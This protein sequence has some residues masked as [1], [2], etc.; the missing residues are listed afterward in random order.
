MKERQCGDCQ[1]CCELLAVKER[2]HLPSGKPYAFHKPALQRCGNQC[3]T[4]CAIY[5]E[6][7][8]PISC[9]AFECEWL[10]GKFRESDR[11]DRSGVVVTLKRDPGG[12]IRACIFGVRTKISG[13]TMALDLKNSGAHRTFAALRAMPGI[14]WIHFMHAQTEPGADLAFYR[15]GLGPTDW[16]AGRVRFP[17]DLEWIDGDEEREMVREL[18]GD[19]VTPPHRFREKLDNLTPEQQAQMRDRLEKR[20]M[21]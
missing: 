19:G 11:P 12:R 20:R 17:E 9:R 18:F 4:G 6:D 8:L 2:G 13:T 10:L 1:L 15:T 5:D 14:S 16:A 3:E 7:F 21:L